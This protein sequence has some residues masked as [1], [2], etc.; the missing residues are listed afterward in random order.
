MYP[1]ACPVGDVDNLPLEDKSERKVGKLDASSGLQCMICYPKEKLELNGRRSEPGDTGQYA[2]KSLHRTSEIDGMTDREYVV[3][4]TAVFAHMRRDPSEM[5]AKVLGSAFSSVYIVS[6]F[7]G[8]YTTTR[9]DVLRF[10]DTFYS[11]SL[12]EGKERVSE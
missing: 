8:V 9:R 7:S 5:Y 3:N 1:D 11:M 2:R 6:N 12:L 10:G 4:N